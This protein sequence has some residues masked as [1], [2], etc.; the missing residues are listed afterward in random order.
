MLGDS[1]HHKRAGEFEF[2]LN[3]STDE[4]SFLIPIK[5][6]YSFRAR[7]VVGLFLFGRQQKGQRPIRFRKIS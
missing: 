4:S 6:N 3:I 2:F 1:K 7:T 5:Y